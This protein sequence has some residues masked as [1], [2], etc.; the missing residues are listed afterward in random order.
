MNPLAPLLDDTLPTDVKI[1][2][3]SVGVGIGAAW[4]VVAFLLRRGAA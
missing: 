2:L 3:A 4:L 1:M